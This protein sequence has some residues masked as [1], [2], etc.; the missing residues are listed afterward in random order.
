M[1][2][3]RFV[4][5]LDTLTNDLEKSIAVLV[6][7]QANDLAAVISNRV[8]STGATGQG[9]VFTNYSQ[10]YGKTRR[11]EGLQIAY[12][13]F[14]F[15][16]GYNTMWAQ[17][18]VKSVEYSGAV[19]KVT[20]GGKTQEAQDKLNWNSWREENKGKGTIIEPTAQ[21]LKAVNDNFQKQIVSLISSRLTN[22]S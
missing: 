16:S 19:I 8:I 14:Q 12:K 18:G 2:L 20:I 11:K 22:G 21:E 17:F 7:S 6:V 4:I 5:N 13:D 15:A 1:T 9:G 10:Q 3:E